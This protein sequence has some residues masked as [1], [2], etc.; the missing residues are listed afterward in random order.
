MQGKNAY[1][2]TNK[3]TLSVIRRAIGKGETDGDYSSWDDFAPM[4]TNRRTFRPGDEAYYA[5]LYTPNGRGIEWM[6]IQH[7]AQLGVKTVS[8]ITVFGVE[9]A[10]TLYFEIED[11]SLIEQVGV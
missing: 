2:V 10:P 3:E 9:N 11:V 1:I 7:K 4:D 5:L 8:E 6:L